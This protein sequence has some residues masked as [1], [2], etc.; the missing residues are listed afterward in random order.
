MAGG[1][2]DVPLRARLRLRMGFS[3]G[4]DVQF[5]PTGQ[6]TAS[7]H[8]LSH[9]RIRRN[10]RL[11]RCRRRRSDGQ[12]TDALGDLGV[13]VDWGALGFAGWGFR[14]WAG[15]AL[16]FLPA[17]YFLML[18]HELTDPSVGPLIL[19]EA[20]HGYVIWSY[21]SSGRTPPGG[22][23]EATWETDLVPRFIHRSQ[24]PVPRSPVR[25]CVFTPRS[26]SPLPRAR[27]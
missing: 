4:Y 27:P 23:S 2:A 9:G 8:P 11:P 20:G 24:F 17:R 26:P 5:L 10:R 22:V 1:R 18:H 19:A 15:A 6:A 21:R 3:K 7:I 14:W 25:V 16:A 12:R 13:G